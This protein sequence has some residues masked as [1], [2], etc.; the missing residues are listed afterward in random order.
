MKRYLAAL[1]LMAGTLPA[2]AQWLDHPW[3]G[4][5][6]TAD[7]KPDLSAAAPRTVDGKPDFTGIWD[8][9]PPVTVL[10]PGTLKP[11]VAELASERQDNYYRTRPFYQCRPSGPETERFAGWKR[12]LQTP[13]TLAILNDDLT[14]RVIHLDGRELE[15]DPAP[16]WMGFSAGHWEG[17]TLV[18]ES[19]G[20]NEET[21]VSRYG[22]SHTT[23]LKVTERYRRTD[24]GHLQVDVTFEDPEAFKPWGFTVY[25]QLQAD[26]EMLESVCERSSETWE[27]TISDTEAQGV[28]VPL[29]VL[30]RYVGIYTGIY[31]GRERSYEVT[32]VDGQLFASIVGDYNAVGLGAAGL[33]EGASRAL[34]PISQTSFEGLGLGYTFVVDDDGMA[35]NMIL[36]HVS[37][38][39][40]YARRQ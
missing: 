3:P 5:P 31:G 37:G 34:L 17:D 24:F 32:L 18:V 15:E 27:G 10:E 29:D 22:V 36:T 8:G 11:W 35:T 7:G 9:P 16:S 1:I 12:L 2:F 21:W 26:T 38:D 28:N 39:Y 14:Y 20:F 23:A 25:M 13:S 30:E 40:D 19:N 33:D 4:I 6:R